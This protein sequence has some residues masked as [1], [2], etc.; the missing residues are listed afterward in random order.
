[1]RKNIT[2]KQF[3]VSC[4]LN[5]LNT[6]FYFLGYQ[7]FF[8]YRNLIFLTVITLDF[9]SIYLFLSFICDISLFIFKSTKLESLNNFLRNTLC[10]VVNPISYA[11]TIIAWG[12]AAIWGM[13]DS[14]DV[15]YFMFLLLN[16]YAHLLI[17]IFVIIDLF[18]AE[19][20]NHSFSLKILALI[21]I[22]MIL[23]GILCGIL[24]INF[25]YPPYPFLKGVN[26]IT[27]IGIYAI[28]SLFFLLCY[29]L[30]ILLFKIKFKFI[31]KEENEDTVNLK[32]EI[33]K[34]NE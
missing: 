22:Y 21:F 33:N 10:H 13:G 2:L 19:H 25:D 30:H 31:V 32:E 7:V 5:G 12:I 24:S 8:D 20:D 1:M 17:S 3:I 27:L 9:N 15:N 29:F 14:N 28:I 6:V 4:I 16:I 34:I 26:I 23:Y 18:I 11:V